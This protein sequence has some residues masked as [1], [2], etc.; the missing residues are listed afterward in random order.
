MLKSAKKGDRMSRKEGFTLVEIIVVAIIIGI[1]ATTA[2][3][4]I[5]WVVERAKGAEASEVLLK[6]Y[7]GYKRIMSD[8]ECISVTSPL[9]WSRLG[10][11]DPNVNSRRNFDYTIDDLNN[12]T[13][14]RAVRRTNSSMWMCISFADGH[15]T[16]TRPY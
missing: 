7:G 1:L 10:M 11:S 13:Y 5:T 3:S 2:F 8:E 12:P 16:K 9:N 15:I 14:A 4:K 6:A